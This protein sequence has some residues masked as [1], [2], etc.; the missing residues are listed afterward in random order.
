[1]FLTDCLSFLGRLAV[2]VFF[3]PV[4][5]GDKFQG[6]FRN[7]RVRCLVNIEKFA[8]NVGKASD[9]FGFAVLEQLAVTGISIDVEE[10]LIA[11]R[12]H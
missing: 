6:L 12:V 3:D 10:A 4:K 7:R 2:D 8:A 1:M 5:R 9:L 11:S